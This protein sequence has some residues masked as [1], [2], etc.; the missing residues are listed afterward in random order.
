VNSKK[1]NY[2]VDVAIGFTGVLSAVSGLVFLL[3]GDPTT[4]IL[5]ISLQTWSRLH[6]WSSLV[7]I[8]GVGA[9]LALHWKWMVA[10]TRQMLPARARRASA[11]GTELA[12]DGAQAN[13]MSRRAFLATGGV[14]MVAAG[15]V[16]AGYRA[17]ANVASAGGSQSDSA[18]A[19]GGQ[20]SGV[21]CPFGVTND[22]YP[23]RCRHYVDSNGDGICDY[24]VPGSG[25]NLVVAGG[26]GFS[27]RR[28][29][30]GQP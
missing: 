28:G 24:S 6:T 19:T 26:G 22:P 30:W 10:V 8:A 11:P 1:L 12:P 27:R 21:A 4:G 7:A 29:N 2:W 9:H 16:A 15:L 18:V 14:V 13:V 25:R 3:P 20:E 17:L 23:G 5:G